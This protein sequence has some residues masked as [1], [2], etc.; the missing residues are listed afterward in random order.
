[1]AGNQAVTILYR[2]LRGISDR[3]ARTPAAG[4]AGHP[5][6]ATRFARSQSVHVDVLDLIGRGDDASAVDLWRRH[7]RASWRGLE[8]L[9]I[10]GDLDVYS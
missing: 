10:A 1:M 4:A 9:G 3:H 5:R 7:N 6:T 8:R 2:L